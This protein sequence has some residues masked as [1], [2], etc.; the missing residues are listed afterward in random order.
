MAPQRAPTGW[1][2]GSPPGEEQRVP[3]PAVTHQGPNE[4]KTTARRREWPGAMTCGEG[5]P[6]GWL[7]GLRCLDSVCHYQGTV[8]RATGSEENLGAGNSGGGGIEQEHPTSIYKRSDSQGSLERGDTLSIYW[9]PVIPL[10]CHTTD[11]AARLHRH[12]VNNQLFT[13]PVKWSACRAV[14]KDQRCHSGMTWL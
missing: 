2:T 5:I 7:A 9:K 10:C 4:D 1:L 12:A 14:R 13:S 3:L 8:V 11:L 6:H